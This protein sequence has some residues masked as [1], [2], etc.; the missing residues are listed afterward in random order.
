MICYQDGSVNCLETFHSGTKAPIG[1]ESEPIAHV[2]TQLRAIE[3]TWNDTIRKCKSVLADLV[4]PL[5]FL[6]SC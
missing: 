4:L 6:V 3:I 2:I 1:I 5:D